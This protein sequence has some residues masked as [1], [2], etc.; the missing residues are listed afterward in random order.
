M[1]LEETISPS[2]S[3]SGCTT[4]SKRS[5]AAAARESPCGAAPEAEVLA[6][7]DLA[8]AECADEHVVD[9]LARRGRAANSAS[10]GITIISCT[11]SEATSSALRSEDVSSRGV[12]WGETTDTGWGSKVSTLSAPAMTSRWPRW[13]PSNVPTAMLRARP[14]STSGRG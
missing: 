13:T 11:P 6:D 5:S 12:C 8:G 14:C 1:W 4:V 3:S 10:K 9:E 7:R 2:I